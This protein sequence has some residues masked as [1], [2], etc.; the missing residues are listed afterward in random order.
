MAK[1]KGMDYEA[2]SAAAQLEDVEAQRLVANRAAAAAEARATEGARA[3]EA[4]SANTLLAREDFRAATRI[5]A[6]Q[7]GRAVRLQQVRKQQAHIRQLQLQLAA[8]AAEAAEAAEQAQ[9]KMERLHAQQQLSSARCAHVSGLVD[10]PSLRASSHLSPQK[11]PQAKS[12]TKPV[13]NMYGLYP[14]RK[15]L[16]AKAANAS[17]ALDRESVSTSKKALESQFKWSRRGGLLAEAYRPE[18]IP[19]RGSNSYT[20]P[21]ASAQRH[22][23]KVANPFDGR[24]PGD[25]AFQ[26][27]LLLTALR[28]RKGDVVISRP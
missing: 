26:A 11:P 20:R 25:V 9:A 16:E 14:I 8:K 24:E 4:A 28:V 10:M 23:Q 22:G 6:V 19:R 18:P 1:A 27:G 21:K 3:A 17:I 15:N 2:Y 5:Q 13:E 7:R 12:P